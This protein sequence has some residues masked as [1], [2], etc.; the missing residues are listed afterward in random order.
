M[1]G[2]VT[3]LRPDFVGRMETFDADWRRMTEFCGA[4]FR[5]PIDKKRGQYVRRGP[6]P[7]PGARAC[8]AGR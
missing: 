3:R 4:D 5:K 2:A 1:S 6:H 8:T 7:V